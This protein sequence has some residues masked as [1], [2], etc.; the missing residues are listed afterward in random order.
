[1]NRSATDLRVLLLPSLSD[2][3]FIALMVILFIAGRG[4]ASLLF[5]ADTGMHIRTGDFILR[6]H[7]V[8]VRDPFS[9]TL[10]TAPWYAWE[11]LADITFSAVHAGLGLKGVV[12]LSGTIICLA[13]MVLFRHMIWRGVGFHIAVLMIVLVVGASEIHFLARPHVF[14][15]LLTAVTLWMLDRDRSNA[16]RAVWLMVPLTAVW[17][18]LHGGFLIAVVSVGAFAVEAAIRRDVAGAKRYGTLAA[19]CAFATLINPYG[20]QLHVHI[21]H[22]LRSDWLINSIDEFQSPV[23]RSEGMFKFEV[24]LFL[25]LAFLFAAVRQKRFADALL[26][27]FWGHQ[28]LTSARHVPI[29]AIAA[30]PVIAEELDKLW[31]RWIQAS[32]PASIMGTIRDILRDFQP[33]AARTS[34][35]VFLFVGMLTIGNLGGR[36]PSD[37]PSERYPTALVQRNATLLTSGG[38]MLNAD[39]WGGYLIYRLVPNHQIFIDGRSDYYGREVVKDYVKLRSA[40]DKWEDVMAKYNFE[41]ALIPKDWPLAGLL[42]QKPGWV[43]RDQDEQGILFQRR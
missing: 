18:N 7:S 21:W 31:R 24:L 2:T 42:K 35:W 12:L 16:T 38:H 17:A 15:I 43:F 13:M 33:H 14:T 11:W 23:F 41:F 29:Y 25:G 34:V 39:F 36:W 30:A 4:W 9:F 40:G 19:A 27:L 28:A 8:P 10:P 1:V 5:D 32:A 6:T 22:Y 3:L 20:W 37:F 26:I